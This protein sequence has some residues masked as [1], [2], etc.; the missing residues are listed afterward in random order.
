MLI[1]KMKKVI[2]VMLLMVLP[3]VIALESTKVYIIDLSYK[4]G[5]LVINDKIVKYG[6]APDYKLQPLEGYRAEIVSVDESI[7]YFFK[8]EIP[9]KEYVDV[10]D[11][12]SVI[13]G[14]LIKLSETDFALIL[15]YYDNAKEI[16]FYDEANNKAASVDVKEEK[17]EEK[18]EEEKTN[19][20]IWALEFFILLVLIVLFVRHKMR[21]K[22]EEE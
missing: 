12:E 22:R 1:A 8:F 13:A 17:K 7:L 20:W 10:S 4:D 6:Y 3:I 16:V 18:K 5:K 11:N 14:G 21:E 9:L 2:L 19:I 15:P